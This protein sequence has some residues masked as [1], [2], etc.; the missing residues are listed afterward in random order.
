MSNSRR[1][2]AEVMMC[3]HYYIILNLHSFQ[4]LKLLHI[5]IIEK[6]HKEVMKTADGSGNSKL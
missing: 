5:C 1:L 3:D 2:T 4:I 6:N